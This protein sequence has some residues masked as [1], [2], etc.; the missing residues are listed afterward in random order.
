MQSLSTLA[1]AQAKQSAA[2][3]VSASSAIGQAA[4]FLPWTAMV[5][6]I[7]LLL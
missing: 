3:V 6:Y 4:F 1:A 5:F 7:Y 2:A